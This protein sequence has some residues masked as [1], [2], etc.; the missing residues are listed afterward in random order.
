MENLYKEKLKSVLPPSSPGSEDYRERLLEEQS[1]QDARKLTAAELAKKLSEEKRRLKEAEPGS[2]QAAVAALRVEAMETVIS[3]APDALASS[4]E[5]KGELPEL[6]Q[7]PV[8]P[9]RMAGE[10]PYL[11]RA[12]DKTDTPRADAVIESITAEPVLSASPAH[13][14]RLQSQSQPQSQPQNLPENVLRSVKGSLRPAT[15]RLMTALN[16]N[17]ES[18]LSRRETADLIAALL[19]CNE[20]QLDALMANK[21]TPMA[22]KIIIKRIKDD[23]KNGSLSTVNN[24]W[25]R[26]FGREPLS[27][28]SAGPSPLSAADSVRTAVR[29]GRLPDVPV[30]REAYILIR[31]TLIK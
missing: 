24:L 11:R 19:T 17:L 13:T 30:S 25:D 2:R 15:A 29:E 20:T 23:F 10:N 14:S 7:S 1:R 28:D 8:A 27:P 18:G 22:V 12:T 31:D 9:E 6:P 16:I 21:K 5:L 26:I 4:K 3:K